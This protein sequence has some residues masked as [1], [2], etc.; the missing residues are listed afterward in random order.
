MD[1]RQDLT[2]PAY[3]QGLSPSALILLWRQT[4][5][6]LFHQHHGY[7]RQLLASSL[8][9]PVAS[10]RRRDFS[11]RL[12]AKLW[13][14]AA[15]PRLP[16]TDCSRARDIPACLLALLFLHVDATCVI[17]CD[18]PYQRVN[19]GVDFFLS[20]GAFCHGVDS[21]ILCYQAKPRY[22]HNRTSALAGFWHIR[23]K[24]SIDNQHLSHHYYSYY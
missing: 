15:L 24:S 14:S 10:P 22:F 16:R 17:A 11:L 2:L 4:L 13:G 5:A 6:P 18:T 23:A 8:H 20:K 1:W 3:T 19:E 12:C 9:L 21:G 7:H